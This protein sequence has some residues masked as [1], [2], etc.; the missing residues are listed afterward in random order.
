MLLEHIVTE[1]RY[2]PEYFRVTFFGNFPAAV[3]HKSIVVCE[4][5]CLGDLLTDPID[6][7]EAS[8]GRNL[9]LSATACS[10]SILMLRF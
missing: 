5:P 4:L 9:V 10:R 3:R 8:T 2:Y 1:Q 7:I 6:S